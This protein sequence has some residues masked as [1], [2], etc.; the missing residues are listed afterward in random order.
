MAF[1]SSRRPEK[2]LSP[3]AALARLEHF[4][5]YR[6]RCPKE[7]R[8]KLTELGVRGT[9]AEQIFEVLREDG[10]FDEERFAIA[11]AGGKFRMNHWGRIRI[12]QE[13]R[14]RDISPAIIQKAL[15]AIDEGAYLETLKQLLEKK[16]RQYNGDDQAREKTAASLIRAGFEQELVFRYL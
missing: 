8:T 14:M 13:L 15:D 4:C 12:R 7:V 3:D 11:Y 9:D 2:P 6:E 1:S 5:A 16:Y 10:F